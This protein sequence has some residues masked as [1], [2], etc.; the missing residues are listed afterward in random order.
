[1]TPTQPRAAPPAFARTAGM[2]VL[3]LL[4]VGCSRTPPAPPPPAPGTEEAPAA[5]ATVTRMVETGFELDNG[6]VVAP[7]AHVDPALWTDPAVQVRQIW[8]VAGPGLVR[9]DVDGKPAAAATKVEQRLTSQGW[10]RSGN[11]ENKGS[12]RLMYEMA[13]GSMAEILA[14]DLGNG[15]S[16]VQL[17]VSPLL[18]SPTPVVNAPP[19]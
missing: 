9:M 14:L 15:R 5:F 13:D 11:I 8:S 7:P 16:E 10:K 3:A 19:P 18:V 6:T 17:S 4:C 1:M 12:S 2:T